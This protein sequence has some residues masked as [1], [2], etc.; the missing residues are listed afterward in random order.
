MLEDGVNFLLTEIMV[1]LDSKAPRQILLFDIITLGPLQSGPG[2][3]SLSIA[4]R[5]I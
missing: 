4:Q 5:D 1:L 2:D 3:P